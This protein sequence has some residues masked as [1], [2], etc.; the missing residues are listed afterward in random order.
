[1]LV[2]TN[3]LPTQLVTPLSLSS[4]EEEETGQVSESHYKS[5]STVV[6]PSGITFDNIVELSLALDT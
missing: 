6:A 2:F 3:R 1:M 5:Y 4:S